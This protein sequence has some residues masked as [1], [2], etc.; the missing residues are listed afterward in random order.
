[1]SSI[2]DCLALSEAIPALGIPT[3]CCTYPGVTCD[4]NNRITRIHFYGQG[5]SAP[6]GDAIRNLTSLTYIDINNCDVR[7]GLEAFRGMRWLTVLSLW[8]NSLTGTLPSWLGEMTEMSIF[9]MQYNQ[10]T[11]EL[12][13]ALGNWKDIEF[14]GLGDNNFVGSVPSSYN[15]ANWPLLYA[16]SLNNMPLTGTIDEGFVETELDLTSTCISASPNLPYARVS[17]NPNCQ[18]SYEPDCIGLSAAFRSLRI[19]P[20]DC[21]TAFEGIGCDP[22]GRVT[23]I[24]FSGKPVNGPFGGSSLLTLTQLTVVELDGAGLIGSLDLGRIQLA[25]GLKR[26]SVVGNK[27][28]RIVLPDGD[29]FPNLEHFDVSQNALTGHLPETVSKWSKLR[30]LGLGENQFDGD[31]PLSFKRESWPSLEKLSIT[32]MPIIGSLDAGFQGVQIDVQGTCIDVPSVLTQAIRSRHRTCPISVPTPIPDCIALADAFPTIDISHAGCC[33][34]SGISCD[35]DNRI[36]KVYFGGEPINAPVGLAI[37]R[38]TELVELNVNTCGLVGGV[39]EAFRN[40]TKL[41]IL[42]LPNNRLSGE[43]PSWLG[44]ALPD[45]EKVNLENNKLTGELP[46]SLTKLGKLTTLNFRKND[47]KGNMPVGLTRA[48]LPLLNELLLS[49]NP[50]TGTIDADMFQGRVEIIRTCVTPSRRIPQFKLSPHPSCPE[51]TMPD[52]APTPDCVALANAFPTLGI[53][54]AICCDWPGVTCGPGDRVTKIIQRYKYIGNSF[55]SSLAQLTDLEYL[56]ISGGNLIGGFEVLRPLRKLK[57]LSVWNNNMGGELP[58]WLGDAFP[59]MEIFHIQWL[60]TNLFTGEI[61]SSYNRQNWPALETLGLSDMPLRGIL[62]PSFNNIPTLS[63]DVNQTCITVPEKPTN[64]VFSPHSSCAPSSSTAPPGSTATASQTQSTASPGT[65]SPIASNAA[66][67]EA[68]A[69]AFPSQNFSSTANCCVIPGIACDSAGRITTIKFEKMNINSS[70]GDRLRDLAEL[71][72]VDINRCQITGGLDAFRGLKK[73]TVLSLYDNQLTGG[74]SDWI[75]EMTELKIL[76]LQNNK[77]SG[78]LLESLGSLRKLEWLL[79]LDGMALTGSIDE[80]LVGR[81]DIRIG[82]TCI[83]VP[84]GLSGSITRHRDCESA[85]RPAIITQ[86]STAG[87]VSSTASSATAASQTSTPQLNRGGNVF[88]SPLPLS[89]QGNQTVV[90]L[91][92]DIDV[93]ELPATIAVIISGT[94]TSFAIRSSRFSATARPTAPITAVSTVTV[95][96]AGASTSDTPGGNDGTLLLTVGLVVGAGVLAIASMGLAAFFVLRMRQQKS[97]AMKPSL[98]EDTERAEPERGASVPAPAA[99]M[100]WQQR[101]GDATESEGDSSSGI[102]EYCPQGTRFDEQES[103]TGGAI[104]SITDKPTLSEGPGVLEVSFGGGVGAT[105]AEHGSVAE[106]SLNRGSSSAAG[107]APTVSHSSA[108]L[109]MQSRHPGLD[110]LELAARWTPSQVRDKLVSMGIG[111]ML[112]AL[113]EGNGVTGYQLLTMTDDGLGALGVSDKNARALMM[114]AVRIIKEMHHSGG[115]DESRPLLS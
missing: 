27:L 50:L 49:D 75:S 35:A 114:F 33:S 37:E 55:G 18:P 57:V 92:E 84:A 7:G 61:P 90:D 10:M 96:I 99:V 38:L 19:P 36:T 51:L 1:M 54:A 15:K 29:I 87:T 44:D 72:Y 91:P 109:P 102:G 74:L 80:A 43:L 100:P 2:S 97:G 106:S 64:I 23:E 115:G 22:Q 68:L 4:P 113:L 94:V 53:S 77:L 26:L 105:F 24:R 12:P 32:N 21:C 67:C 89:P 81:V 14:L 58:A 34:V 73:L 86:S 46:Q 5:I 17:R 107:G 103:S 13:A 66:D 108:S 95:E 11:G 70:I 25:T 111:P 60:G 16:M 65:P 31:L 56:D 76:H 28:T 88:P 110:G 82:N 98:K 40:L 63:I 30:V 41:K 69:A 59:D 71:N 78:P 39:G 79:S 112:A 93:P 83:V 3:D 9:H 47:F 20:K 6:I 45:L 48:N 42:S 85:T 104:A 101:P 8:A 62:D 52:S